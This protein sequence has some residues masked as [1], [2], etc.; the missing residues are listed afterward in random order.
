MQ[1]VVDRGQGNPD[2]GV[3]HF[4]VKHFGR[5]MTI[6]ALEQNL[7]ECEA[8]TG[9]T[10]PCG[11]KPIDYLTVWTHFCHI[12]H[13]GILKLEIRIIKDDT[14]FHAEYQHTG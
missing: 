5:D 9:R 1:R 3:Q 13:I 6:A 4:G 10:Q 7:G 12:S 8:L 2:I 11:A 14:L